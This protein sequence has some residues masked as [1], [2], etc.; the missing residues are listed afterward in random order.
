MIE[1]F[2]YMQTDW[3]CVYLIEIFWFRSG[4]GWGVFM[5]EMSIAICSLAW[6]L[7]DRCFLSDAACKGMELVRV[8]L[9]IRWVLM[10][11]LV[12]SSLVV[13]VLLGS[14]VLWELIGLDW[15]RGKVYVTGR[16]G[17]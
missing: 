15:V 3:F 12:G 6:F 2:P 14:V 9:H 17:G 7:H 10:G 11:G 8:V 5:W 1:L 16:V 4:L 13:V